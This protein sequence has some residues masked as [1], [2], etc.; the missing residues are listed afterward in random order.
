MSA[1]RIALRG[2]LLDFVAAPARAD[3]ETLQQP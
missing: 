3:R 2:D 1:A